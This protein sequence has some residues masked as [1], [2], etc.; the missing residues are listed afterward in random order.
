M[1]GLGE[2]MKL[3]II[4]ELYKY[5]GAEM[6]TQREAKICR[7]NGHI[8]RI[9]TLD[10]AFEDGWIKEDHYNIVQKQSKF[11]IQLQRFFYN[12]QIAKRLRDLIE[13]FEPDYIHINNAYEHALSIFRA[14]RG[15][16][17]LQTIRDYGAVCP[18]G[19]CIHPN[20]IVC[21]GYQNG[22]QCLKEC[23]MCDARKVRAFWQCLC[24]KRRDA[25]RKKYVKLFAC[26]SQMLTDYCIRQGL[27]TKCINNPF[28]FSLLDKMDIQKRTNFEKKTFLYY[29][30]V[31]EHKGIRQ[32]IQAFSMFSEGKDD[33]ELCLLGRI[34]V[35][36]KPV[37]KQ[38]IKDYGH[39]KVRYLGVMSYKDTI[40]QLSTVYAV[41]IPS[42][43]I[44]NYPNTALEAAS[45]G[46]LV[47]AS[48]RGGMKEIVGDGCF[49][50]HVLQ[51]KEIVKQFEAAYETTREQY[52]WI[53]EKSRARVR[54][55]NTMEK[56]YER[57]MKTLEQIK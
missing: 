7:K 43:W 5:G 15:Y 44:E 31:V 39:G 17:T 41:V 48:E 56:Y 50:F 14:V 11:M 1:F 40:K 54:K 47:L 32:M 3:L 6:Q 27:P 21:N 23:I 53:T 22:M 26:P 33:V 55:N 8:V 29:G 38:L 10:P 4:N 35:E 2:E 25:A 49:V 42:L 13:E 52:V 57:L 20:K 30:Q 16:K 45:I 9:I 36:Y 24:F 37:L 18:N 19:L 51:Q 28:D 34:P 46:C 12:Y